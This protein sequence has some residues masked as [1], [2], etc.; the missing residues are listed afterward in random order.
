M[1]A[2]ANLTRCYLPWRECLTTPMFARAAR[3]R[4]N[5]QQQ[6]VA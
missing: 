6:A 4:L 5:Q 1:L 2:A 3:E